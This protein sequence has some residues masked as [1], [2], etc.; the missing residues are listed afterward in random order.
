M[1]ITTGRNWESLKERKKIK[2]AEKT[3]LNLRHRTKTLTFAKVCLMKIQ[4]NN[5]TRLFIICFS[6]N[7]KLFSQFSKRQTFNLAKTTSCFCSAIFL[8]YSFFEEFSK[9]ICVRAHPKNWNGFLIS[10]STKLYVKPLWMSCCTLLPFFELM[11]NPPV[12]LSHT[13]WEKLSLLS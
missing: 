5:N 6:Q 3:I 2:Y 8:K 9:R 10:F 4:H 7:L 11:R 12:W 13:V 1:V